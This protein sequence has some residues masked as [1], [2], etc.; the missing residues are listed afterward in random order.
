MSQKIFHFDA[1]IN[2]YGCSPRVVTAM[3]E[4]AASREF[5]FYGEPAAATLKEKL[6]RHH[7][8]EPANFV[9]FNGAGEALAWLYLLHL[10]MR[11]A[12]QPWASAIAAMSIAS[13][14]G[15]GPSAPARSASR[16]MI[17]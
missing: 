6:A 8:L 2:P 14:E 3:T 13:S 11:R 10:V 4:L 5:R 15:H 7:Q 16:S 12:S 9:V 17:A 1:A